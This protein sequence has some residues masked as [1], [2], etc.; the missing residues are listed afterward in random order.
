MRAKSLVR[1]AAR[2]FGRSKPVA[3]AKCIVAEAEIALASRDLAWPAKEL[4]QARATLE[5]H[6]DHVNA[7]HARYL[8]S[9]RSEEDM[10]EI[11]LLMRSSYAAFCSKK[12]TTYIIIHEMRQHTS[13]T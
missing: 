5:A 8:D 12:K 10:Y 7:A 2:S 11:Q 9:R 13:Y 3:R 6:G 4:N 1:Q